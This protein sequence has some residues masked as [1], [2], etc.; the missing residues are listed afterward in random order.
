MTV[1]A[2]SLG[3]LLALLISA[4]TYFNDWKIGQTQLIGNFLP[5]SVFGLAVVLLLVVNPLLHR[6][7]KRLPLKKSEIAVMV[8]LGL[9]ACGWPGSNLYRNFV[10]VT[11]LPAHWLK[12][13]PS[14]QANHVMSYVPGGS[15][16]LGQGH[17][18]DWP[19]VVR[20]IVSA[21]AAGVDSPAGRLWRHLGED[22]QRLFQQAA[23]KGRVEVNMVADL[24]R[25]LNQALH[26]QDL[27]DPPVTGRPDHEVV[28]HNRAVLAHVFAGAVL[29]A[30]KGEG[31]LLD[32]GRA[33]PF[34]V[35]TLMQGRGA[36]QELSLSE[37]PWRAWWPTIRLW[38]SVAFLLGLCSLCLALVVH[39]QWSRREL[40]PYP[41]VRFL[42]EA[43]ARK[44]ERGWPE[45]TGQKLFWLGFAVVV[46]WHTLNGL[47][48][49]FPEVPEMPFQQD[50]WALTE[51]FPNAARVGGQYGWFGPTIFLSVI[52][53]SFFMSTSAS[54]SLGISHVLFLI[55]GSLMIRNGLELDGDGLGTKRSNLLRFGAYLVYGAMIIYTGRH[56]YKQVLLGAL[57]RAR[58]RE[59]PSYTVWAAR[60]LILASVLATL[61]L[62]GSGLG[63][64]LSGTF[65]FLTLL[66]FVVMT[67]MVCET[68]AFFL[69]TS[70]GPV[71][72]MTALFGFDAIGPTPFV[73]LALASV[74]L[75]LDPRETLMPFLQNGL[76]MTEVE[77]GASP[78][79]M[80]PWLVFVMLAGFVVAGVVSFSLQ[81]NLS[82]TQVG[83]TWGTHQL[84]TV[85]FSTLSR[86]V[87]D[88]AARG[89]L[90]EATA[91][92]GWH[93]LSLVQPID[94][95]VFWTLLGGALVLG[96][97]VARL[98]LPWWPLHPIAFLVWDT[99]PIAMFG[100]SFLLGWM[101]KASVVGLTGAR[102]Y[103][104]VKP[105]MIGVIAGELLSG[106][107]WMATGVVYYFITGQA[108][109]SYSIF[110]R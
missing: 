109:V 83:N 40:L 68:G 42:D 71:G 110:P 23:D 34:L 48:A 49:W 24:T 103:H 95:A 46:F 39:P 66:T 12:T 50:L 22:G 63:W 20:E 58:S 89:S 59:T 19:R 43:S 17:V 77:G 55:F 5:I 37:L 82:A 57:G 108:S 80:S 61:S 93:S 94:D 99:Y 65:V 81:Y 27:F 36:N 44:P 97:S 106:L 9:A 47:H 10:T 2:V 52:A 8:A 41:I 101:V 64:F 75:V 15:G 26:A 88:S 92:S 53:F 85:A 11:A 4:G 33:D 107:F 98:R 16:E 100:V 87:A 31:A 35:D 13:N 28:S 56:Y 84:P 3:L 78:G 45:V 14:W 25:S 29:P 51:L 54:F 62:C 76:K 21:G 79:R 72:V 18:R 7:R 60:G 70:W 67:R 38:G 86:F 30:P 74:L 73:I 69:Q 102:G 90:A 104:V 96:A 91:T 32:G 105:L 6:V 1:R